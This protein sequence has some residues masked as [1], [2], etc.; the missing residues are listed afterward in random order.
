MAAEWMI[1]VLFLLIAVFLLS[2]YPVALVLAGASVLCALLAYALGLFDLGLLRAI[3]SRLYG[4]AQNPILLTIPMFILMGNILERSGVA[5]DLL[6]ALSALLRGMRGGLGCAVVLVGVLMGAS[7]G[8]VGATVVTLGIFALPSL[9]KEKYPAEFSSGLICATGTL[10]QLVPPSIILILLGDTLSASWQNTQL[11]LNNFSPS[12]ISV[13]DLFAAALFPSLMLGAMYLVYVLWTQRSSRTPLAE[14][15]ANAIAT[16]EATAQELAGVAQEAGVQEAA[17]VQK[18]TGMREAGVRGTVGV[19]EDAVM[20]EAA[21]ARGEAQRSQEGAVGVPKAVPAG[22]VAMD[23]ASVAAVA[24]QAV[25]SGGVGVDGAS[26]VAVA[27]PMAGGR[28]WMAILFPCALIVAVL[29]SIIA[30]IAAPSEASAV[31]V[32]AAIAVA[33]FKGVLSADLLREAAHATVKTSA[34]IFLI[35]IGASFFSLVF[36]GLGGDDVVHTLAA[37]IG[38]AGISPWWIFILVML[39]MFALGFVLDFIE[40]IYIVVPV[41]VPLLTAAGFDP[42]WLGVMICVNL[43]TSFLTPPFG[44]SLFYYRS[45]APAS[46]ATTQIYKGVIPFIVIQLLALVVLALFPEIATWLPTAIYG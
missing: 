32:L 5:S 40:I 22:D 4:I 26:V 3:P 16:R 31:G 27:V 7:T 42:L 15:A 29:G 28:M 38:A 20:Q 10:G 23:G 19:P 36:R 41:V 1:L 44:F 18:V 37:D 34:M 14:V 8:I 13:G 39:L 9:L 21:V 17:G 43:Q 6:A 12:V 45:I 30:G 11:R 33:K 2:G 35:L 25:S 46:I 24:E